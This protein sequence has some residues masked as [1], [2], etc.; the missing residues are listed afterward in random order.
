MIFLAYLLFHLT[1]VIRGIIDAILYSKKGAEALPGNEHVFLNTGT[2]IAISLFFAGWFFQRDWVFAVFLIAGYWPGFSFFHNGTYNVTKNI[3][4][5]T[6]MSF[7]EAWVDTSKTSTANFKYDFK[8][9]LYLM[10]FG[11]LILTIGHL[12]L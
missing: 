9:R 12:V 1:S 6:G 5:R 2:I 10:L 7:V 11:L 8:S 3:I 4:F